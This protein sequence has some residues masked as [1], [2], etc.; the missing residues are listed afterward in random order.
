MIKNKKNTSPKL[1]PIQ[2]P[3]HPIKSP[4]KIKKEEDLEKYLLQK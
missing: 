1:S 2:Q 4:I 3:I